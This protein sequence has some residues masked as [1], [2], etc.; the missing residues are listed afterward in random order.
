MPTLVGSL[1]F[2]GLMQPAAHIALQ[3]SPSM[4]LMPGLYCMPWQHML[5]SA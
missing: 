4:V 5:A 2:C 1:A 3:S